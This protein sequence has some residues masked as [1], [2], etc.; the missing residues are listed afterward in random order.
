MVGKRAFAEE[1]LEKAYLSRELAE[2]GITKVFGSFHEREIDWI[3]WG[4]T[5]IHGYNERRGGG[6]GRKVHLPIPLLVEYIA[7]G[8]RPIDIQQ[9]LM[10]I[11]RFRHVSQNVIYSRINDSF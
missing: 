8:F 7:R 9:A 11:P 3:D 4:D 10:Q 2:A 6:G 5:I 1:V